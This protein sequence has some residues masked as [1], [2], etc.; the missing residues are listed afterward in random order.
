MGPPITAFPDIVSKAFC[1]AVKECKRGNSLCID[2]S[3]SGLAH[4][5]GMIHIHDL[6]FRPSLETNDALFVTRTTYL[7]PF[8]SSLFVDFL[9]AFLLFPTP[10]LLIAAMLGKVV[11]NMLGLFDHAM[12]FSRACVLRPQQC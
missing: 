7:W 3:L 5:G 9:G 1:T 12:A 2:V 6:S 8:P 4:Y 11:G 10:V